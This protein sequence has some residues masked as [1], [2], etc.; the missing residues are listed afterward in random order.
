MVIVNIIVYSKEEGFE[1]GVKKLRDDSFQCGKI[2][3]IVEIK[4][5]FDL[6]SKGYFETTQTCIYFL[7]SDY[8]IPQFIEL[9]K[10]K[11][12]VVIN[13]AFLM[14]DMLTSKFESLKRARRIGVCTP[15]HI[16]LPF[17]KRNSVDKFMMPAFVKSKNPRGLVTL[18]NNKESLM[19]NLE[20]LS[21]KKDYY[22]EENVKYKD[23]IELKIYY[24]NGVACAQKAYDTDA[25]IPNWFRVVLDKI[26]KCTGLNVFSADFFVNWG[27]KKYYCFDINHASSFY[28][29]DD[30]RAMF[31][32]K[33][34]K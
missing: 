22:L 4:D 25:N 18:I 7:S 27:E 33:I 6:V 31:I 23:N 5:L 17:S 15:K 21:E 26:S 34:L 28:K 32:G 29:S 12:Q 20:L 10:K 13:E 2:C 19:S 8:R 11:N 14:R 1:D 3:K 24:I 16:L 30:A 9:I